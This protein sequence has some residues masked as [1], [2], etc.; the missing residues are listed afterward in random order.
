MVLSSPNIVVKTTTTTNYTFLLD[1][2]LP[3]LLQYILQLTQCSKAAK[4]PGNG[5]PF[6]H[7]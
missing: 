6:D 3:I 5:N 4:L 2:H 1:K 7:F